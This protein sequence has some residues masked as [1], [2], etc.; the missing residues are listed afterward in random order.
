M[1]Q[2]LFSQFTGETAYNIFTIFLIALNRRMSEK[3]AKSRAALKSPED[4]VKH[5][6]GAVIKDWG[7]KLPFALVYPNSYY[8]GMSNLGVHTI[9][10]QL[11]DNP[12]VLGERVFL[13]SIKRGVPVSL[14]SGRPLTDFAV[15]AFSISYELDYFNVAGILKVAGIPL[16]TTNRD[17]HHPL[18]IA[19]GPCITA[20]P[21]PLAPFFDCLCIGEAEPI[22]PPMLEVLLKN[23]IHQ[24]DNLLR[25]LARIP[26]LY[27]PSL[28]P[29]S[30]VVRQY[31]ANLDYF[32]T[33]SAIFTRDTELGD[34]YLTEAERGCQRGCRFCLVNTACAPMRFRSPETLI[35]DVE[36]KLQYRKR[37]GLIGPAVTDH[38][39]ISGLLTGLRK[40]GAE[41]SVSSLRLNSLSDDILS[42]LAGGGAR[43][44]TVAPEAGSARLRKLINKNI[45]ENDVLRAAD[46]IGRH[47][48]KNLKLYFI[49]GLPTETDED[50]AEIVRLALAIK[51]RL[52]RRHS[53]TRLTLN[54]APFVPKAGTPFQWLPM[55]S[56]EVLN[57]RITILKNAL[58]RKGIKL[59]A[60]S[61]AWSRVQGTL[62]RGDERLAPAIAATDGISLSDWRRVAKEYDLDIDY[63]VNNRW[64]TSDRLPWSIIDSGTEHERL[65]RELEKALA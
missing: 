12:K 62:S 16:N 30:P 42:A 1:G 53:G 59:N 25:E 4:R 65:C 51:D 33:T 22:L 21:M 15:V 27:V 7:G 18:V 8:L 46:M 36:K 19:G 28:P 9:Y 20:N 13:D 34:L 35:K 60:E 49:I 57:N 47:R 29:D 48:F 24:R 41:I 45:S 40:L 3:T 17:H 31:A 14:E 39:Q 23:D 11:N 52:D 6:R 10:R 26:G 37:V 50:T 56:R 38:P 64:S 61:P 2:S 58:P 43:T 63:Y 55:V 44:I 54:V 5:E 32:L